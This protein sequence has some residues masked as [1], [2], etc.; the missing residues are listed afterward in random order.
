MAVVDETGHAW[1]K[2]THSSSDGGG[3]V[4]VSTSGDEILVRDSKD[5]GG[6]RLRFTRTEWAAFVAGVHDGEFNLG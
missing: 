3:C 1:R 5:P 4:E 6:P 2:S